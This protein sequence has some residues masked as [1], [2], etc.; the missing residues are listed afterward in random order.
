MTDES[1][2]L[3]QKLKEARGK[4]SLRQFSQKCGISH[5]YL[6]KIERGLYRGKPISVSVHTLAKLVNSG[7]E[8][9]Y[10]QLIA[11]S[12]HEKSRT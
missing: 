8:I 1:R 2:Y 9:D 10:E 7:I 6:A 5:A 3:S 4:Q 11:A 12:L